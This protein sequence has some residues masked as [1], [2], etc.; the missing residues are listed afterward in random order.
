VQR[1]VAEEEEEEGVE[2]AKEEEE[3]M[4]RQKGD[5]AQGRELC[6]KFAF[7]SATQS[8][9]FVSYHLQGWSRRCKLTF[10]EM[11]IAGRQ[12]PF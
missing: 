1:E 6:V 4:G 12:R 5:I 10:L 8:S 2:E 3:Q 11:N 9:L 7:T